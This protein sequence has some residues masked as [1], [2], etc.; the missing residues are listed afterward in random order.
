LQLLRAPGGRQKTSNR[1]VQ[2]VRQ[3]AAD[4]SRL[5]KM[6]AALAGIEGIDQVVEPAGLR[7]VRAAA[8][9]RERS[10]G[11]AVP[12]GHGGLRLHGISR[13]P[14]RQRRRGRQPRRARICF[15]RPGAGRVF[16]A[17]GRGIKAGVVLDSVNNIDLAPT[18]A[19]LLGLELKNIDG[20]TLTAILSEK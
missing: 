20:S 6:K 19:H 18:M 1:Q 4:G 17:S 9:V 8:A 11:R 3:L 7:A 2:L 10:D 13:R 5:A 14:G 16:I 12:H 15:D